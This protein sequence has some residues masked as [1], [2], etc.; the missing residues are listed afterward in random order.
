MTSS[1]RQTSW[2]SANQ[3]HGLVKETTSGKTDANSSSEI[4]TLNTNDES[5][6]HFE[7]DTYRN[8]SVMIQQIRGDDATTSETDDRQTDYTYDTLDRLVTIE[9]ASASHVNPDGTSSS[10]RPTTEMRYDAA[11]L[12]ETRT[13]ALG[14]VTTFEYD[15]MYRQ[16]KVILPAA[17]HV[18]GSELDN[19]TFSP[20]IV[21][22]Y[23]ANGNVTAVHDPLDDYHTSDPIYEAALQSPGD[24]LEDRTISYEYDERNLRD[25]ETLPATDDHAASVTTFA[26]DALGNLKSIKDPLHEDGVTDR[27]TT[28]VY[29]AIHRN[30]QETYPA[31]GDFGSSHAAPFMIYVYDDAG[32]VTEEQ[33]ALAAEDGSGNRTTKHEY[34]GLNRLTKTTAPKVLNPTT[35][36]LENPITQFFYDAASNLDA[37]IDA[38]FRTT[39]YDFDALN[40]QT[41]T[42]RESTNVHGSPITTTR[43]N[44]ASEV[45]ESRELIDEKLAG[46]ADDV[47]RVWTH[48]YDDLGR[49]IKTI[50]PEVKHPVTGVLT[51]PETEYAYDQVGNTRFV[52]DANENVIEYQYDDL[53]RQIKHITAD[54]DGAGPLVASVTESRYDVASQLRES[55][56]PLDRVTSHEYD[57]QW[58]LKQTTRPTPAGGLAPRM[59]YTYDAVGNVLT[60]VNR[61][62][63]TTSDTMTYVYDN[64]NREVQWFDANND[65]ATTVYDI[66]SRKIQFTDPVDNVTTWQHDDLDRKVEDKI[67]VSGNDLTRT[68]QYD[69]V[70]N[71]KVYEDRNDRV[72][73]Y[74]HDPLHRKL[75]E[76]WFADINDTTADHTLFY[77]WDVASRMTGENDAFSSISYTHDNLD[78]VTQEKQTLFGPNA[79]PLD[80]ITLAHNYDLVSNREDTRAKI[81]TVDDFFTDYALDNIYRTT[82]VTQTS[83]VGGNTVA[84]KH[85]ELTYDVAH[86]PDFV[87]RYEDTSA[88][89]S[90]LVAESDYTWD[91]ASRL[92][93]LD[94]DDQLAVALAT[95]D[96]THDARDRVTQFVS[97]TDGTADYDY[98]DRGQITDADYS[99]GYGVGTED[100]AYDE[101]GNRTD[102][103]LG[104]HNRVSNDGTFTY[105]WDGE[106]N[107]I[108]KTKIAD[109][110]VEVF[111]WDHRNRKVAVTEYASTADADA[112]TNATKHVDQIYDIQNRWI[113]R[114]VDPDG[115]GVDVTT[116]DTWFVYDG[117]HIVYQFNATDGDG[118]GSLALLTNR[119]VWGP[120]RDQI[121]ADEQGTDLETTAGN[122]LWP[123]TDNLGSVR[124]LVDFDST[125]PTNLK[126][127]VVKHVNFDSF[128]KTATDTAPGIISLFGYT[129][130]AYDAETNSQFNST[131]WYDFDLQRWQ[132]VD[133]GGFEMGDANLYRYVENGPTYVVDPSGL[134]GDIIIYVDTTDI[135][136]TFRKFDLRAVEKKIQSVLKS[137]GV[138]NRITV[139]KTTRPKSS[140]ELGFKYD[141]ISYYYE[142]GWWNLN[143]L[144]S[145]IVN[146][147]HDLHYLATR[148]VTSYTH[149]V[150]IV[151]KNGAFVGYTANRYS[152]QVD[153][154]GLEKWIKNFAGGR[155]PQTTWDRAFANVIIH[156]VFWFGVLGKWFDRGAH[157]NLSSADGSLTKDIDIT[158]SQADAI[159]S[160]LK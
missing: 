141:R 44:D 78:R 43:Y 159:E 119:Y 122:I 116:N 19:Y 35:Q 144:Q 127:Q 20:V 23:D 93:S 29:D 45:V 113:G 49:R 156:E 64:L 111:E 28:F 99:A 51:P 140:I 131:R 1:V 143:P 63:A 62:T 86:Q 97:A 80:E 123:L 133:W 22:S 105:L 77:D 112:G 96:W 128:G 17:D 69:R 91:L 54:P 3:H 25:T 59:T 147:V 118:D 71:T 114:F 11:G 30:T 18:L 85:V 12:L 56:D 84:D 4:F 89:P 5:T 52:T 132:S 109:D 108:R 73:R 70:G 46:T 126:S 106:G 160:Q 134:K 27:E 10:A 102:F 138:D 37:V 157:N 87:R 15:G 9:E 42:M 100:Y 76:R 92:T 101:N 110:S 79:V 155:K 13:D 82:G 41:R 103:T 98:D 34:D 129:G 7:Y 136:A 120:N 81:G 61:I 48:E 125:Q 142:T 148:Q 121:L 2:P 104:D 115:D 95:Y 124:D 150:R 14:R 88:T 67:T 94:H 39:L 33:D 32:N 152:S 158:S 68:W 146:P 83:Q 135:P 60:E 149:Y 36:L 57:N 16:T 8:Q 31:P 137:A 47:Y 24:F 130:R 154:K 26:Y 40:R 65:D 21:T 66:A 53:D 55:E 153:I 58:R 107:M 72:I 75:E 90:N 139:L 117:D 74:E 6:R 145:V 38:E 151:N 50:E